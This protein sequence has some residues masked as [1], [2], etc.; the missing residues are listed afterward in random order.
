MPY[1]N[2]KVAGSLTREQKAKIAAEVTDTLER[3]ANKPKSYTYITFEEVKG[4]NWAVAGDLLDS[5]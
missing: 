4:E 5:D 1:V 2:I 3:I